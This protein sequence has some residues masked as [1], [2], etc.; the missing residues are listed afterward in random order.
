MEGVDRPSIEVPKGWGKNISGNVVYFEKGDELSWGIEIVI[1]LD[2]KIK[3][4]LAKSNVVIPSHIQAIRYLDLAPQESLDR[5][6]RNIRSKHGDSEGLTGLGSLVSVTAKPAILNIEPL[7]GL[8]IP[9]PYRTLRNMF[10][11]MITDRKSQERF[12][13]IL[14]NS[15][16]HEILIAYGHGLGD[17][18]SLGEQYWDKPTAKPGQRQQHEGNTVTAEEVLERYN[19][20]EKISA[21]ILRSCYIG[22]DGV[23]AKKIPVV[24]AQGVVANNTIGTRWVR[25]KT[26]FEMPEVDGT[27]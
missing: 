22:K 12:N 24:R 15:T 19:D 9:R 6:D 4:Y 10:L 7:F 2:A 26:V 13:N 17:P 18:F 21:I 23:R 27:R 8:L 20:P 5:K 1:S 25:T 11:T 16:G 3:E 14:S